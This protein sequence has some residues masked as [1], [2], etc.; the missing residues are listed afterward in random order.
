MKKNLTEIL[1]SSIESE[2]I[3]K[4]SVD[5]ILS[6]FL[7]DKTQKLYPTGIQSQLDPRTGEPVLFNAARAS[8]PHDY[9]TQGGDNFPLDNC[10]ICSGHTTGILDWVDLSDG[11]TFINKNMYPVLDISDIFIASDP[12]QR[13]QK[14]KNS[15][16]GL[17]FVQWSSTDHDRDWHN[18]PLGDCITVMSRLSV[19]EKT[20]TA[21]GVELTQKA[22]SD[23][24]LQDN[25]WSISIIKNVGS[26]V[27]GSLEHGHQQIVL[28]NLIPKR[29]QN[30]Q[31][32]L[33]DHGQAFTDFLLSQNADE[34][35]IRDYGPAVLLVP[36]FMR[37]PFDMILAMKDSQ[38]SFLYDLDRE[39]LEAV[40][41]GWKD[42][43][44]IFHQIMPSLN[45]EIAYNIITHNGPGVGLYF[46]FLPFTQEIGGLEHLGLTVCQADPYQ[47]ADRIREYLE[48]TD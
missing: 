46:E 8:R 17:H 48:N 31:N 2:S 5:Q 4:L 29:I 35:T 44:Q 9:P 25:Q 20:L 42:G 33:L 26:A 22:G 41:A 40:A 18:M 6:F 39:E 28:G 12:K 34:L 10:P 3:D 30:D 45:R 27:G 15:V 21:V 1:R 13:E 14:N 32:F 37:R 11:F 38:K 24:L 16:W 7:N 47:T 36:F 23:P 43:A 19:L